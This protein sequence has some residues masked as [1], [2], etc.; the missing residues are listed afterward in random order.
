M[1]LLLAAACSTMPGEHID[2]AV[3]EF[4]V[5]GSGPD[6]VLTPWTYCVP[7]VCADGAPPADPPDIGATSTVTISVTRPGWAL[8]AT[9]R[10]PGARCEAVYVAAV[11]RIDE[12]Q[13]RIGP[14]GPAGTY[15]VDL[16]GTRQ[17]ADASATFRWTA[18]DSGSAVAQPCDR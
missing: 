16:A 11:T 13:W 4:V 5:S 18:T 7:G 14:S 9:L 8:S 6:V 1:V 12:S 2:R 15:D 3:P 17:S 10:E